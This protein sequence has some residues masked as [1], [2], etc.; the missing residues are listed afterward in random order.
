MGFLPEGFVWAL[1]E[2][3]LEEED[4]ESSVNETNED[5]NN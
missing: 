4:I 2:E 1:E 3:N 5:A